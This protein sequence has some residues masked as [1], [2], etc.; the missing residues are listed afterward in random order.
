MRD[1]INAIFELTD[2]DRYKV[3]IAERY[4]GAHEENQ[5][6]ELH[7]YLAEPPKSG[8]ITLALLGHAIEELSS[9]YLTMTSTYDAGTEKG[10]DIRQ[11]IKIW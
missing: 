1:A 2:S 9:L 7:L 8:I 11:S 6:F 4:V 5:D 10:K 3:A